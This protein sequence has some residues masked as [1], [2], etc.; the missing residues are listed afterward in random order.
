MAAVASKMMAGALVLVWPKD[1]IRRDGGQRS[2]ISYNAIRP[3]KAGVGDRTG[4]G[5]SSDK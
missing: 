4:L 1:N 5:T 3:I 2:V